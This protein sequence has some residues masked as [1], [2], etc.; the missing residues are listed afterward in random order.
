MTFFLK[1]DAWIQV[2]K[3]LLNDRDSYMIQVLLY[4]G[5]EICMLIMPGAGEVVVNP[6]ITRIKDGTAHHHLHMHQAFG[7]NL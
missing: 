2:I 1:D 4:W 7:E 3:M 5:I 6:D